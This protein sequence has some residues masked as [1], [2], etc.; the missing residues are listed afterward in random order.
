MPWLKAKGLTGE[1]IIH[2]VYL[3]SYKYKDKFIH[4]NDSQILQVLTNLVFWIAKS[5]DN[6]KLTKEA[7]VD[8][9]FEIKDSLLSSNQENSIYSKELENFK[10]ELLPEEKYVFNLQLAGYSYSEINQEQNIHN[11][12]TIL[13]IVRKKGINF[14]NIEGKEHDTQKQFIQF[15]KEKRSIK[16][17]ERTTKLGNFKIKQELKALLGNKYNDYVNHTKYNSKS[18]NKR[19]RH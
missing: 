2:E 5:K 16:Y 11:S 8:S 14:F 3:K 7:S 17:I 15:I 13:N 6:I 9:A 4:Y 10:K 1:D 18:K 19:G 12:E